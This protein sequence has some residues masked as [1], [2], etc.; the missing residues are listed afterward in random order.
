VIDLADKVLSTGQMV[1]EARET[2][3]KDIIVATESGI[4]YRMKKE[5][6]GKSFYPARD[7]SLCANMKKINLV[8]V[9]RSLEEMIYKVEVPRDISDRARG[10]IEKMVQI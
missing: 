8:K 1:K 10:A 5:N 3:K 6:P 7:L 9:L 4:I 2:E